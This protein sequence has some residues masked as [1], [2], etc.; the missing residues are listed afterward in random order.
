MARAH[1][2]DANQAE[3][4]AALRRVGA[5]VVDTSSLGDGFP[6]I[7]ACYRQGVYLLECK[8][9]G[10]YLTPAERRFIN[11]CPAKVYVVHNVDEALR[12]I[13]VLDAER[14]ETQL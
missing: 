12:A 10:G 14:K 8:R 13:G 7:L 11:N 4:I 2:V 5:F 1:R 6:D 9:R 3:I